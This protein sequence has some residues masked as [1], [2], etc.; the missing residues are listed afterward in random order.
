MPEYRV[1][2]GKRHG[3]FGQYGPGDVVTLTEVEASGFLDKLERVEEALPVP[4]FDPAAEREEIASEPA[5]P[6]GD[7]VQ[8]ERVDWTQVKGVSTEISNA[9]HYMGLD[10]KEALLIYCMENG[11]SAL[12]D[13]PG[14]GMKR[15]RD[16]I[17]W[18]EKG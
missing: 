15:A 4:A 16:I 3:A 9:L 13:I 7:E 5:A 6:T 8:A 17:A 12:T 1:R 10:S 2:E 18:A 11:I 14:V